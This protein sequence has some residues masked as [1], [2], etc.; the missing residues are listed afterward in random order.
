MYMNAHIGI[1]L[2]FKAHRGIDSPTFFVLWPLVRF[3]LDIPS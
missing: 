1:L 2:P 3:S